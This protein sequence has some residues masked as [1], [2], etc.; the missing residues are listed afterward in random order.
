VSAQWC[1]DITPKLVVATE[2]LEYRLSFTVVCRTIVEDV[3]FCG[4]L[5]AQAIE[6]P[7]YLQ[8]EA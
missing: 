2:V 6:Y 5:G 3:F 4:T 7:F 1:A 8:K